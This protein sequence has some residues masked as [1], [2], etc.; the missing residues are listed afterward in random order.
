MAIINKRFSSAGLQDLLVESGAVGT[1]S[2]QG[3]LDGK[4]NNRAMQLR[5]II[6]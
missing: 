1:E 5:K 6:M 4:H 2:V 3:V